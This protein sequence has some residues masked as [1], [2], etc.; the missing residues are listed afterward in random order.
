MSITRRS[1]IGLFAGGL[2]GSALAPA[3]RAAEA[4]RFIDTSG[5]SP[6]RFIWQPSLAAGGPLLVVASLKAQRVHVYRGGQLLG[7]S[8]CRV[9][10]SSRTPTGLFTLTGQRRERTGRGAS[11]AARLAWSAAATHAEDLD[12]RLDGAPLARIPDEFAGLLYAASA[13]GATVIVADE[14]TLVTTLEHRAGLLSGLAPDALTHTVSEIGAR[15]RR[16]GETAEAPGQEAS[17]VVSGR[18]RNAQLIRAGKVEAVTG[19]T[20]EPSRGEIGCHTYSLIGPAQD[21]QSLRWL[22]VGTSHSANAPHIARSE[23]AAAIDRLRFSDSAAAAG[24]AAALGRGSTLYITDA[25]APAHSR[26]PAIDFDLFASRP[27]PATPTGREVASREVAS[28]ERR[29]IRRNRAAA[30]TADALPSAE[31]APAPVRLFDSP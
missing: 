31:P 20:F 16:T 10:T 23:A 27:A 25:S 24:M 18:D 21:G 26:S 11:T 9:A 8:T 12:A 6:G 22:A 30:R 2:A 13:A 19:V 3:V 7:I 17:I 14:R 5:L 29:M 15:V 28:Q 4:A 1:L